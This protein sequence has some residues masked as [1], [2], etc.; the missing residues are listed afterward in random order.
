MHLQQRDYDSSKF[1]ILRDS[2]PKRMVNDFGEKPTQKKHN[3]IFKQTA[4]QQEVPQK[5]YQ[6]MFNC[7]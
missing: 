1:N 4:A 7:S 6:K 3:K 2:S 5:T